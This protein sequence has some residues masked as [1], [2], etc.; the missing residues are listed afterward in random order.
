LLRNNPIHDQNIYQKN[1]TF[2][3][4]N[5]FQ[6]AI[7]TDQVNVGDIELITFDG[8]DKIFYRKEI[9]LLSLTYIGLLFIYLIV[10]FG[11]H[12]KNIYDVPLDDILYIHH[13]LDIFRFYLHF[14]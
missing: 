11:L 12:S 2:P 7:D 8:K 5:R 3:I 13:R 4:Q 9:V 6:C 1:V 14:L 10:K